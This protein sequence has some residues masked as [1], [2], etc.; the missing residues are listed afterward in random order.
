MNAGPGMAAA[1]ERRPVE[2]TAAS[3]EVAA[4]AERW[5]LWSALGLAGLVFVLR[6]PA[7]AFGILNIDESD[8]ALIA[9]MIRLGAVP[10]RDIVDI[11]PPLTYLAFMP[12]TL[13][14][15]VELWPLRLL[16]IA[17]VLATAWVLGVTAARWT[18]RREVGH[19]AAWLSVLAGIPDAP[20]LSTEVLMNLPA[21]LA[22][23]AFLRASQGPASASGQAAGPSAREASR[24]PC[25]VPN[26]TDPP[27]PGPRP[28]ADGRAWALAW[29]LDLAAGAAI[30]VGALFRHQAGI[31]LVALGLALVIEAVRTR[32]ARPVLRAALLAA[33]FALP[34]ALTVAWFAR[35]GQVGAFYEWVIERNL[36]YAGKG[37][38]ISPGRVA[39]GV[40][41]G[42]VLTAPVPW[43]LAT[44]ETVAPVARGVSPAGR[45]DPF[46][47]A[48]VI[49]LW[50]TW[51]PVSLGWRFYEHYFIQFVPPLALL[52]AP[53]A[54]A[55]R[56]GWPA[57]GR[58]ARA[59]L[60][61]AIVLPVVGY[62][63][64]TWGR[65]LAGRYPGQDPKAQAI[66]GW[67][68]D[69][70]SPDERV[71]VWGHFSPIYVLSDRL[72]A[73]RYLTTSVHMGN[74]DP[75]HL[76]RG[77]DA[78]AHASQRD[79]D[80]T[81]ADL[82][83]SQAAIVV[84]TAAADL[85]AFGKVP[86]SAFPLLSDYVHTHYAIAGHPAGADVYRRVSAVP[87]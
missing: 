13:R 6:A 3:W 51:I 11:K 9:R 50:L 64:Y 37:L 65:G 2:A 4:R 35:V 28:R 31:L 71:F 36:L 33:G 44:R 77:F 8:F 83:Q 53:Q 78:G 32:R 27:T 17:W 49:A 69:H 15:G 58:R 84:D 14:G 46:H 67:L 60:V 54:V 29:S 55:I 24:W 75:A 16:A 82:E 81:I 45:R 21:A 23:Y 22:L 66:A 80:R 59:A 42:S 73:T 10:F 87:R 76:P 41:V 85:H 56:A 40:L 57:L 74:F 52:A 68:R 72:P 1:R 25:P 26:P 86:L 5:P 39:L 30:G 38:P 12:A 63:G 47:R 43:F 20:S 34:W 79:V 18:G 70:A 61:A 7:L 48:L 62:V 19:A